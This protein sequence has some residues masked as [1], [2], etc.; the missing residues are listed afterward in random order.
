M[1]TEED[2]Q[3]T[4]DTDMTTLFVRSIPESVTSE[5]LSD[6]FSQFC[7]VK[8]GVVVTD[9]ETNLS[10][11]FGFVTFALAE[12][13]QKALEQTIKA[14]LEG[15]TLTVDFAKRRVRKLK[16]DAEPAGQ[17][18]KGD[19]KKK[20][21]TLIKKRRSRIIIRNL[22]WAVRDPKQLEKLFSPYGKVLECLIPRRDGGRMSGFAFVTMKKHSSASTAIKAVNGKILSG[23][24]M[25][26]DFAVEKSVWQEHVKQGTEIKQEFSDESEEEE[27]EE[28]D[29]DDEDDMKVK[30]DS[31]DEVSEPELSQGEEDDENVNDNHRDHDNDIDGFKLEDQ[32]ESRKYEE[33]EDK[34]TPKT[35]F[36]RNLSYM[37]TAE[38]LKSHFEAFGPVKYALPV[39]DKDTQ[40]P[41]GTGFVCFVRPEDYA[42]CLSGSPKVIDPSSVLLADDLSIDQ[43]YVLDSRVLSLSAAVDRDRADKLTAASYEKRQAV[44]GKLTASDALLGKDKRHLYLLNEGRISGDSTLGQALSTKDLEI[45]S[46]SLIARRKLLQSNPS[47]HLSLTRLAVRNIPRSMTAAQL[48][49]FARKAVVGFAQEVKSEIRPGLSKE[50]LARSRAFDEQRIANGGTKKANKFGVVKQVKI[51]MEDKQAGSGRSRGYGFIEYSSHRN[52]L[53]GLR[54]L[55]AREVGVRDIK[56]LQGELDSIQ[57]NGVGEDK[58]ESSSTLTSEEGDMRKRRLVVEFAIENVEVMKRR[59]ARQARQLDQKVSQSSDDSKA[60]VGSEATPGQNLRKRKRT[61]DEVGDDKKSRTKHSS[62]T[63]AHRQFTIQKNSKLNGQRKDKVSNSVRGKRREV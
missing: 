47:L 23:R 44:Q 61:V 29:E 4:S 13:A 15:K 41:R 18:K 54:W 58:S 3:L 57:N 45:R 38:S 8:H 60:S 21:A 56:S 35:V 51:V 32:N 59:N 20:T 12:D 62:K 26:V 10:R 9:R 48:K 53:M 39:I 2:T 50:E 63:D 17:S 24:P 36:I 33:R 1:T 31:D 34:N 43:R 52:A 19:E 46:Q 40:M 25:A 42:A 28:E 55:N 30:F 11:G 37:T 27:T 16:I 14:K 7:P 5:S 49:L 22:S 6:F